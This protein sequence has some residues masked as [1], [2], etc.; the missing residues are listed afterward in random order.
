MF[1]SKQSSAAEQQRLES[2][3]PWAMQK[4]FYFLLALKKKNSSTGIGSY[5]VIFI[6][7]EC[8]KQPFSLA[9]R[10]KQNLQLIP[11]YYV[12]GTAAHLATHEVDLAG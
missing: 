10:Q 1:H 8:D 2:K 5:C 3:V 12:A 11:K 9:K 7:L 4:T 6:V